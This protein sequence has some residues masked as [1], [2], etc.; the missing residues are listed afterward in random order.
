MNMLYVCGVHYLCIKLMIDELYLC[1]KLIY[2]NII[3][4]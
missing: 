2:A 4:S 3:V 1:V